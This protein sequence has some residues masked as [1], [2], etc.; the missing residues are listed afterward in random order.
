MQERLEA[1]RQGMEARIRAERDA[2]QRQQEMERVEFTKRLIEIKKKLDEG[3]IDQAEALKELE[4]LLVEAK[5]PIGE[6]SMIIGTLLTDNLG[7]ALTEVTKAVNIL[8]QALEDLIRM[9]EKYNATPKSNPTGPPGP[10]IGPPGPVAGITV[11]PG[12]VAAGVTPTGEHPRQA[13]GGYLRR[14][15][16]GLRWA[17]TYVPTDNLV[18]RVSAGEMILTPSQQARLFSI[19]TGAYPTAGGRDGGDIVHIHVAGSVIA[20]RDLAEV[21]RQQLYRIK[22]ERGPLHLG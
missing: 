18:A 16:G 3:K 10:D 13:L 15:A 6:A 8:R 4:A 20:E 1:E 12:W 17:G 19:A 2:L 9:W 14:A 5:V 11:D 21:M 7:E 22:R